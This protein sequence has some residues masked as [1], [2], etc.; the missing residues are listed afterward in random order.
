MLDISRSR[1]YELIAAG[2]L[3]SFKIG[4]VRLVLIQ[5]VEDYI[6]RQRERHA[7]AAS[8]GNRHAGA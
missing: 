3:P 8:A 5:D 7:A 6:D 4:R 2:D 1:V